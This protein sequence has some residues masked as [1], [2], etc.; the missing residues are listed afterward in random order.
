MSF[1][2]RQGDVFFE[3]IPADKVNRLHKKADPILAHGEVTGHCHK[4]CD[5]PISE[6]EMYTDEQGDIFVMNPNGPI[7]VS[8]D[9]HG[10]VEL[11]QGKWI[12]ITRQREYD[13]SEA[14][15]QRRVA[16]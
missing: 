4:I 2:A 9:E 16:D 11:P 10:T 7:F 15:R 3:T 5:P 8:H 6:L 13:P 12:R 14:N 1:Q